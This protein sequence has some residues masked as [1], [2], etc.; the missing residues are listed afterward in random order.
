[1]TRSLN[2]SNLN[3]ALATQGLSQTTLAKQIG[4]TRAAVS[5][6]FRGE[7]FPRP[8][9]LLKIALT[10]GLPYAELVSEA[11]TN[12][13]IIAFRKK[14]ARKTTEAHVARAKDMGRMVARLVPYLPCKPLTDPPSLRAPILDYEYLQNVAN[15]V[16]LKIGIAETAPLDFG[17]LIEHFERFSVVLIPVF[18]GDRK[19]HENALHIHLPD[20]KTTWIYLNLD[21]QTHDFKFWMAHE[22]GHVISPTL[23]GDEA[24]DFADGFAAAILFPEECAAAAYKVLARKT[25]TGSIINHLKLVAEKFMISPITVF[26]QIRQYAHATDQPAVALD[27]KA[28]FPATTKFNQQFYTIRE[29]LFNGEEPKASSYIRKSEEIFDTPFFKVLSAYLRES[30]AGAGYVQAIMN[31]SLVDSKAITAELG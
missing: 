18:W 31:T 7:S 26:E 11:M 20:S 17:D 9:K 10:V 24:E 30:A 1:M 14:G 22:L 28:I 21:S 4:V 2:V 23:E 13:P 6:W 5:K 15:D 25:N 19:A 3:D 16:R 12:E 29:T 8:D 27:D